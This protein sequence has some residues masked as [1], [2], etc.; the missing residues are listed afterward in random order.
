MTKRINRL[1]TGIIVFGLIGAQSGASSAIGPNHFPED[2]GVQTTPAIASAI[3]M[4]SPDSA[5]FAA[6]AAAS[7]IAGT[8]CTPSCDLYA[9][10]GTLA[11]PGGASAARYGYS[12]SSS[13]G[14]STLPGPTLLVDQGSAAS[15]TLHNIDLP[16][17]TSLMI[18]Q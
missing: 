9:M 14:T 8:S 18:A 12:T 13:A 15:I 6:S 2:P 3:G 10:T 4:R 5:R 16:S 17:P 11:L 7:L 1:L